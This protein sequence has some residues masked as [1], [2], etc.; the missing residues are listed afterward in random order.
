MNINSFIKDLGFKKSLKI[1]ANIL[2]SIYTLV[3]I[4][5]FAVGPV[6]SSFLG[7]RIRVQD[8]VN[9]LLILS[10]AVALRI[11]VAITWNKKRIFDIIILS[12]SS[13]MALGAME[14]LIRARYPEEMQPIQYIYN[15]TVSNRDNDR[16]PYTEGPAKPGV[17]R[18]MV[19]GDSVTWG[20]GVR[21]WKDLYPYKLLEELNRDSATYDMQVWAVPGMQVDFHAKV[22][23]HSGRQTAPDIIVYQWYVNDVEIWAGRPDQAKNPP[24]WQKFWTHPYLIGRSLLYRFVESR[25]ATLLYQDGVSYARYMEEEVVPGKR[26]WW[27]FEQEFHKWA[28]Y[29]NSIAKRTI[30]MT[31]PSLPY[32]GEYPFAK[33]TNSVIALTRPH[34]M[35][36]PVAYL[37]KREGV[38]ERGLGGVFE[39]AR[40]ARRG[41]AGPGHIAFGPYMPMPEGGHK[42]VFN[43][44]L[45]GPAQQ[46]AKVALLEIASGEG[47]NILASM[48]LKGGDFG[49]PGQW[50]SF[51]LSFNVDGG[52]AEDV[53]FRIE[54]FGQAD[55]AVDTIDVAVD[56]RVE[57]VNP[58]EELNTFNTHATLFDAHPNARAHGVMAQAL[59]RQILRQP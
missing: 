31:F 9:P 28:T 30:M 18:I 32:K 19:Q 39:E 23:A 45:L 49:S 58:M 12:L 54:W 16:G 5:F 1:L 46:E 25:M 47:K 40:V 48:V 24:V 37:P 15:E 26:N 50:K 38:E 8:L 3:F 21:D 34:M 36:I 41:V 2:I 55:L 4:Y 22:L 29:A 59:A 17:T 7:I 42:A 20:M 53:E 10:F 6:D 43:A 56:Y 33:V 51:P 35:K 11:A 13:V 44:M 14:V 57:V 52:M 27:Y